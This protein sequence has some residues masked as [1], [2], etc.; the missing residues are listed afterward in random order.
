MR[1]HFPGFASC[2]TRS[3]GLDWRGVLQPTPDSPSYLVRLLN[4]PGRAPAVFVLSPSIQRDAPHRY[5]DGTLC[6]Y[7]PKEWRWSASESLAL[8]IVPWTALWLY[9]YELWL[10]TGDWLGP[11]SPHRSGTPKEAA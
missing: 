1:V 7:W 4:E 10:V 6:L 5:S 2:M 8:T 11:S 3:G 9:Y